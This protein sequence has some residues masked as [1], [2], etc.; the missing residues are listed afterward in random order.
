MEREGSVDE[1]LLEDSSNRIE[2]YLRGQGYRDAAAPHTRARATANW[3]I[4]FTVTRG[5]QYQG[6][7]ATRSPATPRCRWRNSSRAAHSATASRLPTRASTPTCRRSR[8]STIAAALPRA[9][10]STAVE[11]VTADAAAGAGAGRGTRG[12]HRRAANHASTRSTFAGQR[13]AHRGR[14]ARA[15]STAA[16]RAVRAGTAGGDRDAIQLAYQNLGYQS[17]SVDAH[18]GASAPTTRASRSRSRSARGRRSSST[19]C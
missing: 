12:D 8:T 2:E 17:A 15:G 18:A 19:T 3:S 11:I 9:R 10:V 14:A 13:G 16:G 1:D 5:Q 4:T 7:V 6:G